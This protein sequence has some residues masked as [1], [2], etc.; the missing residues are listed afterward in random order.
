MSN[1]KD[2]TEQL[3]QDMKHEMKEAMDTQTYRS[4]PRWVLYGLLSVLG[5]FI[6][7]IPA[8]SGVERPLLWGFMSIPYLRSGLLLEP[9]E[10]T[11]AAIY[12]IYWF[13]VGGILGWS[14]LSNRMVLFSWLIIQLGMVLFRAFLVPFIEEIGQAIYA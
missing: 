9:W 13:M 11:V 6:L 5:V 2:L 8:L 4:W 12:C 14:N 10:I 1:E 7:S 3:K